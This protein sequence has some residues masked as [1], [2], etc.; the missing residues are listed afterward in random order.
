[1]ATDCRERNKPKQ[2]W[3]VNQC[4]EIR[5]AQNVLTDL[6]S[7]AEESE[8]REEERREEASRSDM[9]S[10][11]GRTPWLFSQWVFRQ[12]DKSIRETMKDQILMDSGSSVDL[13]CN[14]RCAQDIKRSNKGSLTL[15]TNSGCLTTD[16]DCVVT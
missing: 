3:H 4:R 10:V 13:F 8:R 15:E 11:T 7:V 12:S 6:F 1:M 14:P 9:S 16:V 5:D 2:Q